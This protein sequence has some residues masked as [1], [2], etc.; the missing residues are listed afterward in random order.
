M[1]KVRRLAFAALVAGGVI[2]FLP[3]AGSHSGGG[4]FPPPFWNSL[5]A[6]FGV[7]CLLI[8]S[9]VALTSYR[10][11]DRSVGGPSPEQAE[12][13]GSRVAIVAAAF[14]FVLAVSAPFM[15]FPV[16]C[17][18]ATCYMDPQG[19]WSTIWPN[20]LT[21][22]L[23]F[24]LVAWGWGA[25]RSRRLSLPGLGIGWVLGG[26]VLLM[27][28]LLIGYSTGCPVNGCPPLTASGWWS[29]FWPDVIAGSLGVLLVVLGSLLV[30]LRWPK[31]PG[32]ALGGSPQLKG[33]QS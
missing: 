22:D 30:V 21:L 31:S 19:A 7:L 23:G 11:A 3:Y 20:I 24:V 25:S 16:G 18:I 15:V 32:A 17:N 28:G 2:L 26:I 29:L 13:N 10:D 9:G 8:A 27:L 6:T 33:G 12:S 4:G 5:I 14:G 1:S